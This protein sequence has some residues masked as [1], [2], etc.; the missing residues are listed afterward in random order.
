MFPT[1]P[2]V[3]RM[4]L[5]ISR[6]RFRK[7]GD[8]CVFSRHYRSDEVRQRHLLL[9]DG[10]KPRPERQGRRHSR[11]TTH[12]ISEVGEKDTQR[13]VYVCTTTSVGVVRLPLAC[14]DKYVFSKKKHT[15]T[16][17][18]TFVREFI[19]GIIVKM[20]SSAAGY[21]TRHNIQ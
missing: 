12:G 9:P 5:L 7:E 21:R 18:H 20:L 4:S 8:A 13:I 6:S 17:T 11:K 19:H 3:T 2:E 16:H 14:A 10:Q 1:A 15:H